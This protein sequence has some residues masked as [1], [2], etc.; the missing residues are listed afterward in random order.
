MKSIEE[1]GKEVVD[2]AFQVHSTL[3]PRLLENRYE[4]CLVHQLQLRNIRVESQKDLPIVYKNHQISV[5]YRWD[6][7]VENQ[8]IIELKA[9]D[10]LQPVHKAQLLTYLKLSGLTLGYLIHFN[11]PLLKHGLRRVVLNH[12]TTQP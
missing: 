3:A 2:S 5:G 4:A 6:L 12:P 11:V 9:V 1:I 8:I 7:L 10:L